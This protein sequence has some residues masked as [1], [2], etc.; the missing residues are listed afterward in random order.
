MMCS[1]HQFFERLGNFAK[2]RAA[3]L[4]VFVPG[5]AVPVAKD[6]YI[7]LIW[8]IQLAVQ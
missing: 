6:S 2:R 1:Q 7:P 5:F 4:E 8:K 3:V